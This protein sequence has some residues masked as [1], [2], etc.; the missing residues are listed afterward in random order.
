MNDRESLPSPVEGGFQAQREHRHR[1]CRVPDRTVRRRS[2]LAIA[3]QPPDQVQPLPGIHLGRAGRHRLGERPAP[4]R[5][6]HPQSAA[7][8]CRRGQARPAGHAL[9]AGYGRQ[10]A[11]RPVRVQRRHLID[12]LAAV[13]LMTVGRADRGD[14]L[15]CLLP[16]RVIDDSSARLLDQFLPLR[17]GDQLAVQAQRLHAR[18]GKLQ[19]PHRDAEEHHMIGVISGSRLQQA[20]RDFTA[21]MR[22]QDEPGTAP[23][24]RCRV[25]GQARPVVPV[26]HRRRTRPPRGR[27]ATSSGHRR[28]QAEQQHP[29]GHL[30]ASAYLRCSPCSARTTAGP[31]LL[32]AIGDL[33]VAIGRVLL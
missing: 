13:V 15:P 22:D 29:Q 5:D 17:P 2:P 28:S 21:A 19:V 32:A 31:G 3:H 16:G 6:R 9:Q 18:P 12:P 8:V 4:R 1:R 27:A 20:R 25:D 30:T 23:D 14:S 10:V 24:L 26:S 7:P 11:A 33:I